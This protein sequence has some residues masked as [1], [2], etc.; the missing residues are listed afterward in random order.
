MHLSLK[1]G[2]FFLAW[3]KME[4]DKGSDLIYAFESIKG[5]VANRTQWWSWVS[6]LKFNEILFTLL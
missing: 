2:L 6:F 4:L 5:E 3:D 1:Q